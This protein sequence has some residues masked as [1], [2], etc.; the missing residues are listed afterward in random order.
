MTSRGQVLVV[1]D[2]ENQRLSLES[3]LALDYDVCAAGGV[4]EASRLIARDTF[5]VVV[6]D[7]DMPDGTGEDVLRCV[8]RR[9]TPTSTILLT[10]HSE[11]AQVRDLQKS[12]RALVLFKPVDPVELLAWIKNGVTMAR[13]SRATK[14]NYESGRIKRP[15]SPPLP[16]LPPAPP[17]K[18]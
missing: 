16:P 6:T 9:G 4:E 5:D 10:G 1:D 11:Y 8:T 17:S 3:I 18:I 2:D 13:L 14:A 7:Y 15:P 12:G